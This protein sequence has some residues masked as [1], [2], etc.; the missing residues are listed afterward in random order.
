MYLYTKPAGQG[1]APTPQG[2][3][4]I[5]PVIFFGVLALAYYGMKP[6]TDAEKEAYQQYKRRRAMAR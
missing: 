2:T 3:Q 5:V 1:L 4:W 6:E